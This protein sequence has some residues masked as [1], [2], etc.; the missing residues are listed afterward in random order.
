M[1]TQHNPA[2]H[3]AGY[4][5]RVHDLPRRQGYLIERRPEQQQRSLGG[6]QVQQRGR[7]HTGVVQDRGHVSTASGMVAA[8]N[9]SLIEANGSDEVKPD[10]QHQQRP[11]HHADH[12]RDRVIGESVGDRRHDQRHEQRDQHQ[13]A[14]FRG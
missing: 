14:Q 1:A 7:P 12:Q 8:R 2:T 13:Q 4:S 6:D 11:E 10:Q 3:T 9:Q 5:H